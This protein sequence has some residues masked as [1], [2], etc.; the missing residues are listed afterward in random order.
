MGATRALK[1]PEGLNAV[2]T[3]AKAK[4][5]TMP[6]EPLLSTREV[7]ARIG[8][9][10]QGVRNWH[11]SGLLPPAIRLPATGWMVWKA[12]D[13]EA[14]LPTLPARLPL[15]RPVGVVETRPRKRRRSAKEMAKARADAT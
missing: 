7:A 1:E 6:P 15:G 8:K 13:I 11:A 3:Q 12:A 14:V 5:K 10:I 9:S 2:V 4:A